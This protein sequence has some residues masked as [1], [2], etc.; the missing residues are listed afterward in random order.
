MFVIKY[1][2]LF[3]GISVTLV[4]L[5]IVSI[6]IF[7]LKLGID[8]TGGSALELSFTGTRPEIT[9]IQKD[10]VSAGFTG[11]LVQPTGENGVSIKTRDLTDTERASVIDAVSEKGKYPATQTSFTSIGPSVGAELK[12]KAIVSIVLVLVA[13]IFFVA[14]AFRKVSKP[15]SSWKYAFAVILA[16][17][18]DVVIPSGAFAL[19]AHFLGAEVDTLFIVALL[20]TLALSIADTIVVFDRVRENITVDRGMPFRDVVGKSLSQTFVRSINTSLMVLIMVVS[21]AVFG[22][23]STQLFAITLSIGMFFG[24]YSSIFLASPLLVLMEKSSKKK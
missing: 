10:L 20:T 7:H 18:H 16:L 15:V 22:P 2:K 11:A 1:K 6:A 8:F 14:Y 23:K 3:I 17:I 9:T 24:T 4:A 12:H 19:L 21:L 5:A 13:I